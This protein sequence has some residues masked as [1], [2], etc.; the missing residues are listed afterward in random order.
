MRRAATSTTFT[1]HLYVIAFESEELK[2]CVLSPAAYFVPGE[3]EEKDAPA[4][5]WCAVERAAAPAA[6]DADADADAAEE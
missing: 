1:E 4:G 3:S 6:A 2:T 5:S